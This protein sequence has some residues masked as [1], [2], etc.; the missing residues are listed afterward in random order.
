MQPA[1]A[2]KGT[3][4]ATTAR[5]K[6]SRSSVA[7]N[8]VFR[9][10]AGPD[11]GAGA[12]PRDGRERRRRVARQRQLDERAEVTRQLGQRGVGG[13]GGLRLELHHVGQERA[14][15][16]GRVAAVELLQ[17]AKVPRG[18]RSDQHAEPPGLLGVRGEEARRGRLQLVEAAGGHHEAAQRPGVGTGP[19]PGVVLQ[20]RPH[21]QGGRREEAGVIDAVLEQQAERVHGGILMRSCRSERRPGPSVAAL[22]R[23]DRGGDILRP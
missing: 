11:L 8:G 7:G 21:G 5:R 19:I 14:G 12:V 17:P 18:I 16:G 6:R 1:V 23:D 2:L 13:L 10:P 3:P 20:R 15:P 4:A 9:H 22:P